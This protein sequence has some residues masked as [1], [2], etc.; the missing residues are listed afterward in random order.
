V[1]KGLIL[2]VEDNDAAGRKTKS[3]LEGTGYEVI[4]TDSGMSALHLV[5]TKPV[6]VI[7]LD[8]IL[9]DIDGIRVCSAIK[10]DEGTRD[11]PIIM[12]TAVNTMEEKVR[13]L[14]SG[15]DD[16]LPKPYAEV[17]LSARIYAA[18][19]TKLLRDE[20][21]RKNAQLQGMLAQVETLS[22]TDPLTGLYNRRRFEEVLESEFAKSMRYQL[23]LSLMMIDIDHFKSVNDTYGHAVGDAVLKGVANIILKSLRDVDT[24]CR[25]GGEEFLVLEPMTGKSEASLPARR[26]LETVSAH[27]FADMTNEKKTVS[28]GIAVI[29]QEGIDTPDKLIQAADRA[30]YE[31]KRKGRNRIE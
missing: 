30:L 4:L 29:P 25:W 31:A 15:A 21:R 18:L 16:Y 27:S 23:P 13:G 20:L 10:Q 22:N 12:L 3:F 8:R 5:K 19:R 1:S 24:V 28:I 9:P 17:E 26:I 6:D 14:E 7:L 2:L 11:I